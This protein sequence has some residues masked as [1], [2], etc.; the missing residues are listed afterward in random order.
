[1]GNIFRQ[2][3]A[4]LALLCAV[5]VP[6]GARAETLTDAMIAAYK[7][8]NLLEQNRA[9]L[10]AA[11]EDVAQAVAALRPIVSFIARAT[12]TH[13]APSNPSAAAPTTSTEATLAL[14]AELTLYDNGRNRLAVESAKEAVMATRSDLIGVEQDVLL[15]AVSAYMD[16]RRALE[17]VALRQSNVRLISQ[18]LQATRDRFDVGEVTRTDVSIAEAA[19]AEARSNLVAA[20]GDLVAAREGFKLAVGRYPGPLTGIPPT[21]DLPATVN[22]ARDIAVR[23]HPDI[24]SA[25]HNVTVA[26]LS[27]A[28]ARAALGP[29]VTA[30]AEIGVD[31]YGNDSSS[32]SLTL[33]QPIYR[34]GQL[35]SVERQALAGAD[36]ASAGLLQ[37]V[38]AIDQEVGTSWASLST[39]RAQLSATRE[40]ISAAQLAYEGT[41]EEA[42]L[43]S[44]TTLDVLDSEQDLLD[45]RAARINAEA[46]QYVAVYALLSAMGLL[47]VDHLG[48]GIPTYDPVAYY[49]AVRN[50]P[51][52]SVQGDR[53]DRVLKSIGRE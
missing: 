28:R 17:N 4:G 49:N 48:L 47:T 41:R 16:V 7:N 34:G 21:P 22:A 30:G 29:T 46:N 45:A 33:S 36:Q 39:A 51:V 53:L 40:Q 3:A 11:D 19:L 1:M 6:A 43:G 44:R 5:A 10:R 32:L 27:V 50:A 31:D 2:T 26:R 52:T 12:K 23:R 15:N 9:L 37:T 13:V 25:Q 42:N 38:R 8:S 35:R 14:S 18:E 20:E 24:V